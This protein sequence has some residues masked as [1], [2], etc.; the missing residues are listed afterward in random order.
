[1][2]GVSRRPSVA[3]QRWPAFPPNAGADLRRA[4][5]RRLSDGQDAAQAQVWWKYLAQ[6]T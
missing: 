4:G 5:D 2:A 3:A 6:Q 1:M